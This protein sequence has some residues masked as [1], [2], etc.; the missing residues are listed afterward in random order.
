MWARRLRKVGFSP[1]SLHYD[2]DGS[3]AGNTGGWYLRCNWPYDLADL[4]RDLY[5]AFAYNDYNDIEDVYED[6][7]VVWPVISR[8]DAGR[9]LATFRAVRL[10]MGSRPLPTVDRTLWEPQFIPAGRIV[11]DAD[12]WPFGTQRHPEYVPE[13]IIGNPLLAAWYSRGDREVAVC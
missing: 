8:F 4:P 5:P 10:G 3:V 1:V 11:A 7:G 12:D 13:W 6:W 9:L 2:R